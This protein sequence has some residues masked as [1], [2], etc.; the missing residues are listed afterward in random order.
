MP[1][2]PFIPFLDCAEVVVQGVN[3]ATAAYL[4]MGFKFG[5]SIGSGDLDAL[6]AI[7]EDWYHASVQPNITAEAA[8]NS[9]KA[10]D[11]TTATGPISNLTFTGPNDGSASGA[12]VSNQDAMCVTF[13]TAKRGRS[14]RG[15]NYVPA[16][17][18]GARVNG[19]LW[20]GTVAGVWTATYDD[21]KIRTLAGGWTHVVLSRQEGSIRRTVGVATPVT[22]YRANTPIAT[23]RRRIIGRGI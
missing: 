1:F 8:F 6:L 19:T 16:L 11:L 4:T 13:N 20:T 17:P 5:G 18:V 23:Q 21:L 15:R 22:S 14:Y 3:S 7:I 10:T 9:A 2:L 12:G